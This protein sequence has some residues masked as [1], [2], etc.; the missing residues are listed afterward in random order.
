MSSA[1]DFCQVVQG[2]LALPYKY[3]AG[4]VGS[5]FIVTLRDEKRILGVR[6]TRC[7]KVFFDEACPTL[8]VQ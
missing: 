3:F 1:D 6:C 5:R 8:F 7:K 2:K 4:R